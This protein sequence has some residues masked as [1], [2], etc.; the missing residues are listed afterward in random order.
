M[1][2][3]LSDFEPQQ[4]ANTTWA[5]AK[6][7]HV[8]EELFDMAAKQALTSLDQPLASMEIGAMIYVHVLDIGSYRALLDIGGYEVL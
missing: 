3:Q 1:K 4:V 5:V 7:N 6:S 8:D 2:R